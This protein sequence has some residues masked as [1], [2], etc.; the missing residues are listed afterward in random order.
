M[1]DAMPAK[2]VAGGGV[3][4]VERQLRTALDL[5]GDAQ[6]ARFLRAVESVTDLPLPLEPG[7]SAAGLLGSILWLGPDEWLLVADTHAADA[8]A[9][10]LRAALHDLPAAVTDVSDARI[11][12]AVGG[13]HARGVLAM[14][15]PL[16]LHERAFPAGRCAQTLLAGVPILV[17]RASAGPTFEIHI[18]RSFRDHLEAWLQ[19]AA[20]DGA[21]GA[22]DALQVFDGS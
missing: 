18:A 6:D 3:T 15:C 19:A 9:S 12:Y 14:G 10:S 5:R 22:G 1:S 20:S 4:L 17:H 13:S 8:F 7:T 21:D 16:D 2:R 11:V